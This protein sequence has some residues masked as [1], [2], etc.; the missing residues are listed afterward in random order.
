MVNIEDFRRDMVA[1]S[2]EPGDLYQKLADKYHLPRHAAKTLCFPIAYGM[3]AR[4]V[5]RRFEITTEQ[6]SQ[7]ILDFEAEMEKVRNGHST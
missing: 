2:K 5:S 4:E 3:S 1:F 7:A 6:A